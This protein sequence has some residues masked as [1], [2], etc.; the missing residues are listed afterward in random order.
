MYNET[1]KKEFISS[2]NIITNNNFIENIFDKCEVYE[3]LY[4]KDVCNF[5]REE[6]IDLCKSFGLSSLA[7]LKTRVSIL[8]KYTDYCCN[9]QL[10]I[11]NM[12]HFNE[13]AL[14][15]CKQCLNRFMLN[16]LY[17]TEER[18]NDFAFNLVNSCDMF[19][20][21]A[22]YEGL[23]GKNF[24]EITNVTMK[25]FDLVNK[26]VTLCTGRTIPVSDKLIKYAQ[27]SASTYTYYSGE[28]L[29]TKTYLADVPNVYKY[30]INTT[31][32]TDE[33]A[34]RR[35]VKRILKLKEDL[36]APELTIP[37]LKNSGL[38]TMIKKA[39]QQQ[40]VSELEFLC[41]E[42]S[43]EIRKIYGLEDTAYFTLRDRFK[44]Y[45]D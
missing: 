9:H 10:S 7:T 36:N 39:A 24:E 18:L 34:R 20:L 5:V 28:A 41:S 38:I 21:Q 6:I 31:C 29:D 2:Y 43:L 33:G 19:L 11:D 4:Q 23:S 35:V 44:E 42:K 15:D 16:K 37:R 17:I 8:R 13:I 32:F 3:T 22:F 12:N 1:V 25:D 27:I 26:R 30:R 14:N 45:L 40:N